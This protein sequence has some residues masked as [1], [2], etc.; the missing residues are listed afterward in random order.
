LLAPAASPTS[1]RASFSRPIANQKGPP[2]ADPLEGPP[3]PPPGARRLM[4]KTNHTWRWRSST[5]RISTRPTGAAASQWVEGAG[6]AASRP[7]RAGPSSPALSASISP[8]LKNPNMARGT[9][10]EKRKMSQAAG[11]TH[12]A[13]RLGRWPSARRAKADSY[14]DDQTLLTVLAGAN[15]PTRT[16]LRHWSALGAPPCQAACLKPGHR[17]S[18]AG[19][20]LAGAAVH[21]PEPEGVERCP[22]RRPGPRNFLRPPD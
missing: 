20:L 4:A 16:G 13:R 5:K 12:A 8:H 2:F 14:L 19:L 3:P 11:D 21:R 10:S 6:L 22:Q 15:C 9:M 7:R 1:H 18:S 17:T